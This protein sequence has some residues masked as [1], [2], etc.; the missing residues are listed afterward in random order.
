MEFVQFVENGG[1]GVFEDDEF[2]TII[3]IEVAPFLQARGPIFA[4]SVS[5]F[6]KKFGITRELLVAQARDISI[7]RR[8]LHK[9]RAL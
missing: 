2:D 6:C 4:S 3:K 7:V 5:H 1:H 8:S 9:V